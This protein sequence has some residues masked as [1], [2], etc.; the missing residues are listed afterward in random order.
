MPSPLRLILKWKL[1]QDSALLEDLNRFRARSRGRRMRYL[2]RLGQHAESMGLSLEGQSA[3]GDLRLPT[4]FAGPVIAALPVVPQAAATDEPTDSA[5]YE[6]A[7]MDA[8]V[9]DYLTP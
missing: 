9:A 2:A 7:S 4:A 5:P 6:S 3:N 1:P 8:L